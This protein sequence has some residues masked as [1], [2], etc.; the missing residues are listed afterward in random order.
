MV[1]ILALFIYFFA[2]ALNNVWPLL[3]LPLGSLTIINFLVVF[4]WSLFGFFVAIGFFFVI[5]WWLRNGILFKPSK[6]TLPWFAFGVFR[7]ILISGLFYVFFLMPSSTER[8]SMFSD[9][10][11]FGLILFIFSSLGVYERL[12]FMR[13][14]WELRR[15][16]PDFLKKFDIEEYEKNFDPVVHKLGLL[17][18]KVWT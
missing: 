15:L 9:S 17:R 7:W 13:A 10:P 16:P 3:N 11:W 18:S 5:I 12:T 2:H 14:W 8:G 6:W 1:I 4:L